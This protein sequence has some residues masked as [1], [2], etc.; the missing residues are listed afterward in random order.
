M[1]ETLVERRRG[2]KRQLDE[3]RIFGVAMEQKEIEALDVIAR[4]ER[5]SRSHIVRQAV[6]QFLATAEAKP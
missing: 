6:R 1:T 3:C 5:R 2:A 4:R